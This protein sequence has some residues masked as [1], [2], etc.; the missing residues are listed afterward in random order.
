MT[1][2]VLIIP[3]AGK[4][5]RMT[6]VNPVLPKEMLNVQDKPAIQYAV[7]E[8]IAA[9]ISRV[10]IVV[11]PYKDIIREYFEDPA[12]AR[13]M[14]PK[15]AIGIEEIHRRCQLQFVVQ[16]EPRGEAHAISLAQS[17][18]G[19]G[20][21][22]VFYPDNLCFPSLSALAELKETFDTQGADVIGLAPALSESASGIFHSGRVD[23]APVEGETGLFRVIKL[24]PKHEGPFQSRCPEELRGF[25]IHMFGPHLFDYIERAVKMV[26]EGEII[27]EPVLDLIMK[28]RGLLGKKVGAKVFDIGNPAGYRACLKAVSEGSAGGVV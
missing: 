4:G 24:H 21:V 11:S 15:G 6:S 23:L 20:P 7:E 2:H 12:V 18:A 10:I 14:S 3:A 17:V 22:A 8:G 9:G 5:T 13:S 1:S 16:K 19:T 28:E 27:D 26:V 25:G